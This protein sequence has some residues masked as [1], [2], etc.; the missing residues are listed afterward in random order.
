MSA[1]EQIRRA[2]EWAGGAGH[3]LTLWSAATR[4]ALYPGVG[5]QITARLTE[6]Q[7]WRYQREH[8]R[9]ALQQQRAA[10]Y[11]VSGCRV[12]I[13]RSGAVRGGVTC[14]G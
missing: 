12:F 6:S 14:A 8:S 10:A 7:T 1:T 5:Q 4:P 2:Q 3:L 9:K 11:S 13:W